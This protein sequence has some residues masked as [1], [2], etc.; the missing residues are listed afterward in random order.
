M[1]VTYPRPEV[2]SRNDA[3]QEGLDPMTN[4]G[5]ANDNSLAQDADNFR[6]KVPHAVRPEILAPDLPT[7]N[8]MAPSDKARLTPDGSQIPSQNGQSPQDYAARLT[9][10][11][12]RTL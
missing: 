3:F 10:N 1:A 6:A 11:D 2:A 12:R 9:F 8:G 4:T 5:A 7:G